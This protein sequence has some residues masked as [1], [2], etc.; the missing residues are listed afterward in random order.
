MEEKEI[1][2]AIDFGSSRTG[3]A[4]AFKGKKRIY[5]CKFPGTGEKIKTLN[6]VIIN[7]S[8]D[9]VEYGFKAKEILK[10]GNLKFN[11]QHY[12][13]RIKMALYEDKK[14]IMSENDQ[15]EI[16]IGLLIFSILDYLK[17]HAIKAIIEETKGLGTQIDY[18]TVNDKIRWILTVPAI[19]NEKIKDIMI[20]A[21]QEVGLVKQMDKTFFLALEPEAASYYCLNEIKQ[22]PEGEELF[23]A[24]YIVC[25]LGGGTA[26]I[27]CHKRVYKDGEEKLE[28][29]CVPRG[30][31]FGSNEINKA[32]EQKVLN[33][34]FGENA[35]DKLKEE[36]HESLKEDKD[37]K[38]KTNSKKNITKKKAFLGR[39]FKLQENINE[40]KI[41]VDENHAEKTFQIDCSIFFKNNKQLNMDK[42][43][44]EY[45][46]KCKKEWMINIDNCTNDNDDKTISFPCTIFYD[47]TKELT[48]KISQL[49]LGILSEV[50]NVGMILYVGG[51]CN[52]EI[53]VN[54]IKNE[55]NKKYPTIKHFIPNNPDNAVVKG[56]V[57][58]GFA[59]ER[60]MTRKAPYS[61]GINSYLRWSEEFNG[62]GKK[63]FI[64]NYGYV[65]ENAFYCFISK[66]D[67][68][69][70]KKSETKKFQLEDCGGGVYCC[71]LDIY[72]SSK[73]KT[74]FIDEE[75]VEKIGKFD[76]TINYGD[77]INDE[78]DFF[79]VTF[80]LGG[81]FLNV[82]ASHPKSNTIK[83]ME[84]EN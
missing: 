24:P 9:V 48:D 67:D 17:K 62:K 66:G 42:L 64:D 53:A 83:S 69:S 73:R 4:Y 60:I 68:I 81:T 18:E 75:G 32:F 2:V 47:L 51:F 45:N 38:D 61:L 44:E 77:Y 70:Y 6:E 13:R 14:N 79:L 33:L 39:Y 54:L 65:C 22:L 76:F 71:K 58:Y 57:H 3:Y 5:N 25:D 11:D 41:S 78:N 26:D 37:N 72:K 30:G 31:P 36:F 59:P 84:F 74:L 27:V 55:I 29:L 80:E 21:A 40:S 56:A 10:S 50:N 28:E 82:T 20:N 23:N 7:D 43:I 34:L 63:I 52:S 35:L 49:I 16:Y 46:K 1:V 15:K 8:Y 12:Y 19:W